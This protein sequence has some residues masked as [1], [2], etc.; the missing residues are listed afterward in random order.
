VTL[1]LAGSSVVTASFAA[2]L[3]GGTTGDGAGAPTG[4]MLKSV[5]MAASWL[6]S[7]QIPVSS[8]LQLCHPSI[9][10]VLENAVNPALRSARE[11]D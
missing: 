10:T 8:E 3:G 1:W 4:L 6:A 11:F 7:S 2:L 9:N 5:L